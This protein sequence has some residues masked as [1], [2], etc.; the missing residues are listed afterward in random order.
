[1]HLLT[2]PAA[3][4]PKLAALMSLGFIPLAIGMP[5]ENLVPVFAVSI[6][7]T[8]AIGLGT[9]LTT[10]GVGGL[11]GTLTVAYLSKY[12]HKSTLQLVLGVLFGGSLISFA[13]FAHLRLLWLVYPFVF[14]TGL[15]GGAYMVINSTLIMTNI[16]PAVYGRVMGVYMLIQSIR[17]VSVLPISALA[18]K[19]GTDVVVGVSGAIVM[20]FVLGVATL[21]PAYREIN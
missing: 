13:F 8:G 21:Y 12:P 14:L 17:P 3:T 16:D 11:I 10:T 1:M 15:T 7:K 20:L 9:L 18:E 5:Y 6:L 4:N 2:N 19:F